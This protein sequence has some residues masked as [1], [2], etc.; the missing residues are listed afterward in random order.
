[1]NGQ[2]IGLD[3][4]DTSIIY[5]QTSKNIVYKG[6]TEKNGPIGTTIDYNQLI[7]NKKLVGLLL[8]IVLL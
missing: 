8:K 2:S 3:Y 6:K 5:K 7:I 1:L 4:P